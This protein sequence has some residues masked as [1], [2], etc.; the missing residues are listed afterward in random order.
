M[1]NGS[2]NFFKIERLQASF[3][4]N[5]KEICYNKGRK[6]ISPGRPFVY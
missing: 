2:E 3:T 4:K 5:E 6:D 1:K